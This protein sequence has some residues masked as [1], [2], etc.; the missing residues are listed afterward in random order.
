MD[1]KKIVVV[2]LIITIVLSIGSILFTM[3]INLNDFFG[4]EL[5]PVDSNVA[6]VQLNIN[7]QPN[8]GAE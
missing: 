4:S 6:T 1:R 5:K 7:E 2:L 8:P 3:N